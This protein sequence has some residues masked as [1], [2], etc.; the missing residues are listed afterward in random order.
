MLIKCNPE[1]S[2]RLT[3]LWND[4]F[5][6]LFLKVSKVQQDFFTFFYVKLFLQQGLNFASDIFH[7]YHYLMVMNCFCG[8]VDRQK[9]FRLISSREHCQRFSPSRISDTSRAG[10]EPAQ[11]MSLGLVEWSCAVVIITTPRRHLGTLEQQKARGSINAL[12][13]TER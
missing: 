8:M 5:D 11:T 3:C 13:M 9:A 12:N 4:V 2:I 10:F 1:L 7:F 6:T